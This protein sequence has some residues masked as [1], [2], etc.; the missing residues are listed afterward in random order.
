MKVYI[1]FAHEV[2]DTRVLGVYLDKALALKDWE[3]YYKTNNPFTEV[4][5]IED[6]NWWVEE[7]PDE[8]I[9]EYDVIM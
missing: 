5:S 1:L 4:L 2:E 6:N 9:E 3:E 7:N 8:S